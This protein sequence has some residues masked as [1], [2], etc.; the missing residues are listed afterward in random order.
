MVKIYRALSRRVPNTVA[1]LSIELRYANLLAC[2][3]IHQN[4]K[5]S[6][7]RLGFLGKFRYIGMIDVIVHQ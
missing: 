1:S 7:L 6:E 2:G 3:C 5:L 4:Q